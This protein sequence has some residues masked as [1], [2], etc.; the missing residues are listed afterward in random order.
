[1]Q[2]SALIAALIRGGTD[3]S[4]LYVGCSTAPSWF[5]DGNSDESTAE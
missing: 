5:D 1:M 2:I 4:T 3:E